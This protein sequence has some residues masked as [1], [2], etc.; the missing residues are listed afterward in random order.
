MSYNDKRQIQV[1]IVTP[2]RNVF[3]ESAED[4]VLPMFDGELGVRPGRAPL[5]GRL[6]P[7]ELRLTI[8]GQ[9]RAFFIDGGFVQITM[10]DDGQT[11]V[12][13][14]TPKAQPI[15]ELTAETV[16]ELQTAAANIPADEPMS[17]ENRQK[18]L[19]KARV[20]NRLIKKHQSA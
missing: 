17:R 18:I 11:S 19:E 1:A 12:S 8:A 3:D 16:E 5:I 13:V 20:M 6:G 7:G 14:L 4:A 2:E 10:S 9:K 15:A